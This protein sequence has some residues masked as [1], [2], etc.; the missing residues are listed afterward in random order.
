VVFV[1]PVWEHANQTQKMYTLFGDQLRTL[2]PS[3]PLCGLEIVSNTRAELMAN[4][5]NQTGIIVAQKI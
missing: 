3:I 2:V 4:P 1:E 5:V